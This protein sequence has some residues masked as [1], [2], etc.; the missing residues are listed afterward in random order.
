MQKC[1]MSNVLTALALMLASI[2]A[3]NWGL[4]GLFNFNL[5]TY[6]FGHC[7]VLTKTLY[8]LV[9]ISGIYTGFLAFSNCYSK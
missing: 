9:G 4:V 3:I 5:V 8:I 6:L 2:G 1:N 7:N